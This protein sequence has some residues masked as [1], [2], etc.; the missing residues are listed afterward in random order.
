MITE[1]FVIG[2]M[3]VLEDGQIQLRTDRVVLDHDGTEISRTY[4]RQVLEPGQ[5]VSESPDTRLKAVTA[6]VWTPDVVQAYETK[7]AANLKLLQDQI[8]KDAKI[9]PNT[10]K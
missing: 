9:V 7:K 4:H 3:S 2:L 5:D 1:K 8:L 6:T 10:V